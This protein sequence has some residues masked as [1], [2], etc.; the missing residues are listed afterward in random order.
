MSED[1]WA[2]EYPFDPDD[3][4]LGDRIGSLLGSETGR[5]MHASAHLRDLRAYAATRR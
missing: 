2:A 3:R 1:E 4:T 5:F